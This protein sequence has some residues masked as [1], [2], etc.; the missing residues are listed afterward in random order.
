MKS[1]CKILFTLAISIFVLVFL[2]TFPEMLVCCFGV[3]QLGVLFLL[4]D[5]GFGARLKDDSLC[6][7]VG[8]FRSFLLFDDTNQAIPPPTTINQIT[9]S[10]SGLRPPGRTEAALSPHMLPSFALSVG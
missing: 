5:A 7:G 8:V 10:V 9:Q 4:L 3:F 6:G 1:S 2:L